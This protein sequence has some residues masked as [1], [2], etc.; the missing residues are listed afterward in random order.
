MKLGHVICLLLEAGKWHAGAC[1]GMCAVVEGSLYAWSCCFVGQWLETCGAHLFLKTPH[2]ALTS[3]CAATRTALGSGTCPSSSRGQA[4]GLAWRH[5][6]D[7][8]PRCEPVQLLEDYEH[9]LCCLASMSCI[10]YA[11]TGQMGCIAYHWLA[12]LTVPTLCA[13][14]GA[15][16]A[17]QR[18]AAAAA[19]APPPT[20]AGGRG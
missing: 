12:T 6:K 11:P 9:S 20:H 18:E 3:V 16:T 17:D 2:T 1:W 8:S 7:L 5:W 13:G 14:Q 15:G 4:P 19:G 10:V